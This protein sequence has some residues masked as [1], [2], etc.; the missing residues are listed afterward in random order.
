MDDCADC[1]RVVGDRTVD[2]RL[3]AGRV[4]ASQFE[5]ALYNRVLASDRGAMAP[6][7]ALRRRSDDSLDSVLRNFISAD[8]LYLAPLPARIP[9]LCVTRMSSSLAIFG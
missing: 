2:Y 5:R 8:A 4:A 6:T 3:S 1:R 7:A 9:S